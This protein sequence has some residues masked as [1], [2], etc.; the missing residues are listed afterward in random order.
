MSLGY[1]ILRVYLTQVES[2][3]PKA[4]H[5]LLPHSVSAQN[6]APGFEGFSGFFSFF[7]FSCQFH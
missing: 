1:Y 6:W 5:W 4:K 7:W 3:I 2:G